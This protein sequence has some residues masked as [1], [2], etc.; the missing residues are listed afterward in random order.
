[1]RTQTCVTA[2]TQQRKQ[3]GV[4]LGL[5]PNSTG[6]SRDYLLTNKVP[7][8][9]TWQLQT[10]THPPFLLILHKASHI[11]IHWR[12]PR[13]NTPD[14]IGWLMGIKTGVKYNYD[15]VVIIMLNIYLF[16]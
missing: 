5:F 7:F 1:M 6:E 8:P 13:R 14:V 16:F 12:N 4:F 9:E 11:G 10:P 15:H 3:K 2:E